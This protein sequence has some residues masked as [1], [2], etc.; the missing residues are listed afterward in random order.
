MLARLAY[1]HVEAQL[2]ATTTAASRLRAELGERI[3]A[4]TASR[5]VDVLHTEESR[6]RRILRAVH[7][8]E[9]ALHD[10][11]FREKL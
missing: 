8:V 11:R 1:A 9:Q 10:V 6:L 4:G 7:L 2:A 5:A 3:D